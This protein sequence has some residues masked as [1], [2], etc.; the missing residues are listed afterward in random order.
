MRSIVPKG[1]VVVEADS[2]ELWEGELLAEEAACLAPVVE[3]RRRAFAAGRNCARRALT[4]LG[5]APAPILVGERREPIWPPGVV[6]SI[7]HVDRYCAA[8]VAQ[9]DVV[10]GI[11]IDAA[12]HAPLDRGVETLVCT[13]WERKRMATLPADTHWNTLTFS[14][15][16][17]LFKAWYPIVGGWLDF[18][19]AN[20]TF[21]PASGAFTVALTVSTRGI[22]FSGRFAIAEPYILT[23]VIASSC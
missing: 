20:I 10:R 17:S 22:A 1:V 21:D 19:D 3:S 18:D 13:D 16:E 4:L 5:V 7:T 9:R 14:A 23:A 6:G 2:P 15:K 11:G 12:V 8:A